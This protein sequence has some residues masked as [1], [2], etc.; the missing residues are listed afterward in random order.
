MRSAHSVQC[1]VWRLSAQM[2][3]KCDRSVQCAVC[4]VQCAVWRLSAQ[5][6]YLWKSAAVVSGEGKGGIGEHQIIFGKKKFTRN[7]L[8]FHIVF[9]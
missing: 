6:E 1:A 2:E 3:Y 7:Q 4:S 9:L 5:M 8:H